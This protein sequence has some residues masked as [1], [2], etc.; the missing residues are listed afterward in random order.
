[1]PRV[2]AMHDSPVYA[3]SDYIGVRRAGASVA[4]G[5]KLSPLAVGLGGLLLVLGAL[6]AAWAWEGRAARRGR[7]KA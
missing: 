6:V 4:K 3:G 7:A 1:M 5:V 2:V